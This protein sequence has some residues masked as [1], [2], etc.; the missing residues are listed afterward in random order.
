MRTKKITKLFQRLLIF[1]ISKSMRINF[2]PSMKNRRNTQILFQDWLK[3]TI[4]VSPMPFLKYFRNKELTVLL[5]LGIA[6]NHKNKQMIQIIKSSR[7]S[8]E[9]LIIQRIASLRCRK[10]ISENSEEEILMQKRVIYYWV[11]KMITREKGKIGVV[12]SNV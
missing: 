8:A 11:W 3:S 6:L 7:I 9:N 1:N 5:F 2:L 12:T 4:N 10:Q